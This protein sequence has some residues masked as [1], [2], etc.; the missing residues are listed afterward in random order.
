MGSVSGGMKAIDGNLIPDICMGLVRVWAGAGT[1]RPKVGNDEASG[2][3]VVK[4]VA[5]RGLVGEIGMRI[6]DLWDFLSKSES[7]SRLI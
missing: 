3:W 4:V 6:W 5:G 2:V 1:D 7:I